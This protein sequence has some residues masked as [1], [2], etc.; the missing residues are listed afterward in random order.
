MRFRRGRGTAERDLEFTFRLG[1][2]VVV[3]KCDCPEE[4]LR[5]GFERVELERAR[6]GS[7]NLGSDR[8]H[9]SADVR[10]RVEIDERQERV[11]RGILRIERDRLL[12]V[13][14]RAC[15]SLRHVGAKKLS[16]FEQRFIRGNARCVLGRSRHQ[17]GFERAGNG[18]RDV[19]LNGEH[20]GQLA[21]V[22]LGPEVIAVFG[23]DQ[24]GG[25]ADSAAR[26]PDAAFE[27]R[28]DA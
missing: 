14:E 1:P 13:F 28:T 23:V 27:N 9:P 24:L 3:R 25:H 20:I 4:K 18:P 6:S 21:V 16:R 10:C 11:C 2:V 22:P 17:R 8:C 15:V 12:A 19:V 26:A 5:L 7:A